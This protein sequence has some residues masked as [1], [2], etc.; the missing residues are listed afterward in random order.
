MY[1]KKLT[2]TVTSIALATGSAAILLLSVGC[3]S[4]NAYATPEPIQPTPMPSLATVSTDPIKDRVQADPS[5]LI[6]QGNKATATKSKQP[7]DYY[8]AANAQLEL[9]EKGHVSGEHRLK[10]AIAALQNALMSD[11]RHLIE[12]A[13][14]VADAASQQTRLLYTGELATLA[15]ART[16]LGQ[17]PGVDL[18]AFPVEVRKIL[19]K[20]DDPSSRS[21]F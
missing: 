9:I 5:D 20:R 15:V 11:N 7:G 8:L 13:L 6:S 4:S 17:D 10:V 19:T 18:A 21:A 3:E 12:E 1:Y 16:Y 14:Q 2:K